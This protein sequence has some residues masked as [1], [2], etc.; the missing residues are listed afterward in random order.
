[1]N[2][3]KQLLVP[4]ETFK[5]IN[6]T[7]AS[8]QS[9]V[10]S[11]E[12]N[13]KAVVVLVHGHGEHILGYAELAASLKGTGVVVMGFD[14]IGHGQSPGRRGQISSYTDLLNDIEQFLTIAAQKYYGV[15]LFLYGHSLGGGLVSNY[16]RKRDI[17]K[18]SGII[19]ISPWLRL[20]SPPVGLKRRI[21]SFLATV[22]PTVAIKNRISLHDLTGDQ[23]QLEEAKRDNLRHEKITF[24][25]LESALR[26]GEAAIAK[27]KVIKKPVLIVHGS[28]DNV[29]SKKASEELAEKLGKNVT[30][31]VLE[32]FHHEPHHEVKRSEFFILIRDWIFKQLETKK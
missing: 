9:A 3:D 7:G 25:L 14:Q 28:D 13:I 23:E 8:L 4:D 29:T 1:M 22:T 2:T 6:K 17:K 16:I 5:F 12:G 26:H 20:A 15:P 19:I 21:I 32:G 24:Q 11:P 31:V 18:L 30:Y 10:W 27:N